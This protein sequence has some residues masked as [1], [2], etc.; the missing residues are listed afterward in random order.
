MLGFSVTTVFDADALIGRCRGAFSAAVGTLGDAVM[1][2]CERFV[3]YDT[4]NLCRSASRIPV[5]EEA[6]LLGCAVV[7]SS[8][9]A[10]AVYY[11]DTRGIR[12][13]TEHHAHAR[14]RW[15][16]GAKASDA[17]AWT[18]TVHDTVRGQF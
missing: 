9:Y 17:P 1:R 3:P 4:G 13:R 8:P 2:D 7:W 6:D 12:Y 15:F 18:Q 5:T 14:A 11:G 10:S 16:E